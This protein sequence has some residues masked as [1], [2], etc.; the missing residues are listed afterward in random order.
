MT[1]NYPTFSW[2]TQRFW[3]VN[4]IEHVFIVFWGRLSFV[5]DFAIITKNLFPIRRSLWQLAN[6]K[7]L[8]ILGFDTSSVNRWL[9]LANVICILGFQDIHIYRRYRK[10]DLVNL[11]LLFAFFWTRSLIFLHFFHVLKGITLQSLN[12]NDI[13]FFV[14][15]A[16]DPN[17]L[18]QNIVLLG[19]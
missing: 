17:H 16:L 7:I 11:A 14:T 6:R 10:L 1:L 2:W 3:S 18:V 15:I 5:T 19:I 8:G 13:L 9:F 4:N 12:F